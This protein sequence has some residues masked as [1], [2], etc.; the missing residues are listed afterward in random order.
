MQAANFDGPLEVRD[1]SAV[2]SP[3]ND[4]RPY[5]V[6]VADCLGYQADRAAYARLFAAAPDLLAACKAVLDEFPAAD[7]RRIERVKAIC[8]AAIAKSEGRA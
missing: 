5:S 7:G 8:R 6:R 2:F 4:T 3:A 1:E